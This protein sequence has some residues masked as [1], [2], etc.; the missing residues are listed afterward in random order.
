MR[1]W[2]RSGLVLALFLIFVG[3]AAGW[4]R[5]GLLAQLEF[6]AYDVQVRADARGNAVDRRVV[7]LDIDEPSLA[8][9]GQWPWPRARLAEIVERLY[10]DYGVFTIGFDI[11]FAEP[12]RGTGDGV[13]EALRR[14][15]LGQQPLAAVLLTELQSQLGGDARFAQALG[16][17]RSVMGF[18]LKGELDDPLQI[19]ALPE[20]D[21]P[22]TTLWPATAYR[23]NSYTGNVA[24]LQQ[25]RGG[26]FFN[27]P[28]LDTDGVFRRV[29]LLQAHEG[30]Y[31]PS[32]A[33]ATLRAA[34]GDPEIGLDY[35]GAPDPLNIEALRIGERYRVPVD[36]TL[37]A[38]V[39]Y[40]GAGGAFA[41]VA[42]WEVLAGQ[43]DAELLKDAIVLV[44]TTA[45]G[46][47]DL[48]NTPVDVALPGVEVHANLITGILDDRVKTRVPYRLGIV[49]VQLLLIALAMHLLF[50]RLPPTAGT[51]LAIGM[52]LAIVLL[53]RV[54]WS[55]N[56]FVMPL[57]L[58]LAF[59]VAN[60][61]LQVTWSY[62]VEA[63]SR[64]S[65]SH[66]FGQ[67]VPPEVVEELA[68]QPELL[69]REA[70][71]REL[72]VLFSDVRGFTSI[73]E[74]LSPE[75]LSRLMNALLTPLTEVIHAHRGTI[76][77]Y[78]GDAI[79]AFWGAPL[80]QPQHN[81]LALEA[82]LAM[83]ARI[84]EVGD[85]FA[86]RGW[87]RLQLGIGLNTGPMSV[88]NMGSEFRRAYT[89]L[90]DAVNLGSRLEGLTKAYGVDIICAD[91]TRQ[92]MDDWLF[93]ELDRVR[94]KGKQEPVAIFEPLGPRDALDKTQRRELADYRKALMAYR[95]QDWAG[96]EAG[97]AALAS[98][99]PNCR[100]YALYGERIAVFRQQ[101]P[102][103][104]WDGVYTHQS[105]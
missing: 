56:N 92:G 42:A 65:I 69:G 31:Y 24:L 9:E 5:W 85:D 100:L 33:L 86:Q 82:A 102:G 83:L 32:L 18:V 1:T 78:M 91:S 41:R 71:H 105:K 63:R 4:L 46:L 60:V 47:K 61:L 104:D 93:R 14:S 25:G 2:I 53:A 7:V 51:L 90:G 19:G 13:F 45:P 68:E 99:Q 95:E 101:P 73:S 94:V 84:R 10:R 16:Q 40:S 21:L 66:A 44:G 75:E 3:H 35:D 27:N 17:G 49:I 59:L 26:G 6:F 29:A 39:P 37:S 8:R 43:A 54:A 88:G 50:P 103:P 67:Y 12:G 20:S 87:P 79:M 23:S 77:K 72:T 96:A 22:D 80:P 97:F 55:V 30:Q 11:V 70:E 76:D 74:K 98:A 28:A 48:R 15:E 34:L 81:R 57:G 62:F 38:L 36:E 52:G 64:R 58:P 89:V